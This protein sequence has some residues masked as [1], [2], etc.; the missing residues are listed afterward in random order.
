[1]CTYRISAIVPVVRT[2]RFL[3]VF[4]A[5]KGKAKGKGKNNAPYGR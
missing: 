4:E 1:M 5:S 3:E 2:Q